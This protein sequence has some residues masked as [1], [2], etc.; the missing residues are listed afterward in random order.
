MSS[1]PAIA[2]TTSAIDVKRLDDGDVVVVTIDRP[3]RRNAPHSQ[4]LAELHRLLDTLNGDI[5]FS[6]KDLMPSA[7][8]KVHR[9]RRPGDRRHQR[10]RGVEVQPSPGSHAWP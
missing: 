1:D 8:D 9:L 4:T 3:H 6:A 2:A 5:T 7:V 10:H